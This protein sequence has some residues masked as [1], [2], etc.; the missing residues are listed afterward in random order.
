[1]SLLKSNRVQVMENKSI[2]STNRNRLI[3]AAA[4]LG[5]GIVNGLLGAGGGMIAVPILKKLGLEQKSA[6]ANAVAIILPISILSAVLYLFKDYV[7]LSDSFIYIPTG[8]LGAVIGAYI[9]RKISPVWLKRIFG[10]F[11]VYAGVRLLL[12]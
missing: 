2:M 10:G 9:L 8:V 3:T 7:N 11:M 12:K 6:H 1:M 4:G 5:I